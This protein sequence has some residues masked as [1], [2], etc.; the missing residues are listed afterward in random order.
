MSEFTAEQQKAAE[1]IYTYAA[2]LMVQRDQ[3][4]YQVKVA[5]LARGLDEAS[6]DIVI[7]N[8]ELQIE[9]A[10]KKRANKDMLYGALWCIGGTVITVATYSAASNG[11]GRYFVAWG[12]IL[13]GAIQFF[14]GL[15]NS[16]K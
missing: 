14:K 9:E 6:A 5:L 16:M 11:G 1:D 15:N 4:A 12:A 2:G 13:Y 3:N 7:S 8:L 10:R